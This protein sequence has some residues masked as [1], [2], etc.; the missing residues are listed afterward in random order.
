MALNAPLC[1]GRPRMECQ[2]DTWYDVMVHVNYGSLLINVWVDGILVIEDLPARPS[3][4]N[5]FCIGTLW[6]SAGDTTTV[7]FDSIS[8]Y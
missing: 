8:I 6:S 4:S 7:Y 5:I 3:L 1:G 2:A